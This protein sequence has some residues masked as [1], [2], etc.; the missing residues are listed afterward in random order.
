M[1]WNVSLVNKPELGEKANQ[2]V[3]LFKG[4]VNA[5]WLFEFRQFSCESSERKLPLFPNDRRYVFEY[6]VTQTKDNFHF[7][8]ALV[9]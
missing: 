8:C 2:I 3:S 9:G 1:A 6:E 7:F 4:K 5:K